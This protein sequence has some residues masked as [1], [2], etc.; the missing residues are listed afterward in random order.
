MTATG[1]GMAPDRGRL[2]AG[3]RLAHALLLA[4]GWVAFGW[5]WWVVLRRFDEERYFW[6]LAVFS[7]V[8]IP[9]LTVIW[10]RHNLAIYRRLGPRRGVRPA[11]PPA[12]QDFNGR[13]IEADWGTLTGA[14]CV[15]VRLVGDAKRFEPWTLPAPAVPPAELA[16]SAPP[17]AAGRTPE[18]A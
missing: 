5:L 10:V 16:A 1:A 17:S 18:P 9:A 2:P 8:V 15:R 14:Q 13:R 11:P 3:R 12:G 4:V 6:M 7:L